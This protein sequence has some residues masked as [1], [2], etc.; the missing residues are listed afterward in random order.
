MRFRRDLIFEAFVQIGVYS[1]TSTEII[2][3]DDHWN[4]LLNVFEILG[5]VSALGTNPPNSI[6]ELAHSLG[7]E[8]LFQ[9]SLNLS[10]IAR[11]P[12]GRVCSPCVLLYP[13]KYCV[14]SVFG[15]QLF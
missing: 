13:N 1:P 14:S 4:D 10:V 11:I 8:F 5:H 3:R 15:V 7:H 12:I 9:I 2:A 6:E